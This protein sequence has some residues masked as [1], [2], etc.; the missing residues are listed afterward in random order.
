MVNSS[1]HPT[2]AMLQDFKRRA[3]ESQLSHVRDLDPEKYCKRNDF[4]EHFRS[5]SPE[6]IERQTKELLA[7]PR[8][9][10][11]NPCL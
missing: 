7:T 1:L 5:F 11:M 9:P 4:V 2:P 10:T 6:Q 3:A 8:E